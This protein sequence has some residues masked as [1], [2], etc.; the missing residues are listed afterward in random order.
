MQTNQQ[1]NQ[2]NERRRRLRYL[3]TICFLWISVFGLTHTMVLGQD[4]EGS[5]T[6]TEIDTDFHQHITDNLA[7][8][9]GVQFGEYS[10]DELECSESENRSECRLAKIFGT[11]DWVCRLTTARLDLLFDKT[12]GDACHQARL[13]RIE[14]VLSSPADVVERELGSIIEVYNSLT[15]DPSNNR[16]SVIDFWLSSREILDD[17]PTQEEIIAALREGNKNVREDTVRVFDLELAAPIFHLRRVFVE[18]F[19]FLDELMVE[20]QADILDFFGELDDDLLNQRITNLDLKVTALGDSLNER[21]DLVQIEVERNRQTLIQVV[22]EVNEIID[23]HNEEVENKDDE[24]IISAAQTIS[25]GIV[26]VVP[27]IGGPI[28]SVMSLAFLAADYHLDDSELRSNI[29]NLDS[30]LDENPHFNQSPLEGPPELVREIKDEFVFQI[31]VKRILMREA[32]NHILSSTPLLLLSKSESL[33]FEDRP[34]LIRQFKRA[35]YTIL[36]PILFRFEMGIPQNTSGV[37]KRYD[38]GILRGRMGFKDRVY[39]GDGRSPSP[40]WGRGH[41]D[42]L[43]CYPSP[44]PPLNVDRYINTENI[45]GQLIAIQNN[46]FSFGEDHDLRKVSL[47]GRGDLETTDFI[48][49]NLS[50][51]YPN[52]KNPPNGGFAGPIVGAKDPFG[53][54]FYFFGQD[55]FGHVLQL[56]NKFQNG[57][58]WE[59][60]VLSS[61]NGEPDWAK[62]SGTLTLS[63][64]EDSPFWRLF[65]LDP[66]GEPIHYF[67]DES[68][69][70]G[71]WLRIEAENP[72]PR[73]GFRD[74]IYVVS[75]KTS[76]GRYDFIVGMAKDGGI[77]G[78]ERRAST[79]TWIDITN[80]TGTSLNPNVGATEQL[81]DITG[82]SSARDL[83]HQGAQNLFVVYGYDQ[84][85]IQVSLV[86]GF[87]EDWV[88]HSLNQE[89][90]ENIEACEWNAEP[91]EPNE[92]PF[93]ESDLHFGIQTFAG[94]WLTERQV[95]RI[96]SSLTWREVY[97]ILSPHLYDPNRL[98]RSDV[99][100]MNGFNKEGEWE[101]VVFNPPELPT[102]EEI[103]SFTNSDNDQII[104]LSDGNW[105]FSPVDGETEYFIRHSNSN[106]SVAYLLGE[107]RAIRLP[108]TGGKIEVALVTGTD[109]LK[110][111]IYTA[112][113][114]GAEFTNSKLES[115]SF[116]HT[117][118]SNVQ[119]E[120]TQVGV[121]DSGAFSEWYQNVDGCLLKLESQKDE[122]G[123]WIFKNSPM[124][125]LFRL[126]SERQLSIY[127]QS[128]DSWIP[129]DQASTTCQSNVQ[130]FVRGDCNVDGEVNISDPIV[131]LEYMFRGTY[132]PTCLDSC[133]FD[134]NGK[135]EITDPI[136][137]LNYQFQGTAP[138]PN[139][140]PLA[141]GLDPTGDDLSCEVGL[142]CN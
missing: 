108:L 79:W 43:L 18:N 130:S 75:S 112:W 96:L 77:I 102:Q 6:Q 61:S 8:F 127:E 68:N 17:Q 37:G 99:V 107:E 28:S 132:S 123:N 98:F 97:Q 19:N 106:P 73:G 11:D 140:G 71:A 131:T 69:Q 86:R 46:L 134:D 59:W 91:S 94:T 119:I 58:I 44:N 137:S 25:T 50:E 129:W 52:L 72:I 1:P 100:I 104:G 117:S 40:F 10:V 41:E 80:K 109:E 125:E 23:Q 128:N 82:I 116:Q 139:P 15:F 78:L 55:K 7:Y 53:D 141:C 70:E 22:N 42:Q 121:S 115:F 63:Y 54:G 124:T 62:F 136:S 3:N 35:Y 89:I 135:L 13:A 126:D 12:R 34:Q 67:W 81:V 5:E 9:S 93:P 29:T 64:F 26:G 14:T 88:F 133:D 114:E 47:V 103:Y 122:A 51:L 21:I 56:R 30:E 36:L 76:S 60:Q 49:E 118:N 4:S 57:S 111:P 120:L 95:E 84:R 83:H 110:E 31:E 33:N 20:I 74:R 24:F 90:C 105:T 65:G 101:E 113:E 87:N 27:A 16:S 2:I 85:G 32:R 48:F 45:D 38:Y 66:N 39:T 142:P 138:P 92:D